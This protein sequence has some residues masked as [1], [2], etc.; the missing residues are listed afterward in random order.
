[1]WHFLKE[2][3]QKGKKE[4]LQK[5]NNLKNEMMYKDFRHAKTWIIMYREEKE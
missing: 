5:Q 3:P 1:M 4:K 2:M